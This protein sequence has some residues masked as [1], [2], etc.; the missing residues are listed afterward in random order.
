MEIE[1]DLTH[2]NKPSKNRQ[3]GQAILLSHI[4]G[5]MGALK[6]GTSARLSVSVRCAQKQSRLDE[7][8]AP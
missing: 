5:G 2:P 4:C 3:S 6:H 1:R 7:I 8:P